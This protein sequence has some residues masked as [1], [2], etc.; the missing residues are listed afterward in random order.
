[1]NSKKLPGLILGLFAIAAASSLLF[2]SS[3]GYQTTAPPVQTLI[4][5][6]SRPVPPPSSADSVLLADGS[7]PVPPPSLA[8]SVLLADGSRP[9]PPPVNSRSAALNFRPA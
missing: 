7:R 2:V 5:D 3:A 1:M 8:D 4:A 9:V 6:G